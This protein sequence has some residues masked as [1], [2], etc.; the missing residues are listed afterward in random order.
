M[1]V[2]I[3]ALKNCLHSSIGNNSIQAEFYLRKRIQFVIETI[4]EICDKKRT[5]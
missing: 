5:K 2:E 4:L 3:A 1:L